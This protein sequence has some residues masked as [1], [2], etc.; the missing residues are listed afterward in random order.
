M[1][2]E[3]LQYLLEVNRLGTIS[4]AA[5]KLYMRQSTLSAIIGTLEDE[6]GV[7]IF[8]RSRKGVTP[9]PEGELVLAFAEDFMQKNDDLRHKLSSNSTMRRLISL[10][11]YP[12]AGGVLGPPLSK[13]ISE[14]FPDVSFILHDVSINKL[15]ST[16]YD[17]VSRI[18]IGAD[19]EDQLSEYQN[20]GQDYVFEKLFDDY[21]YMVVSKDSPYADRQL[22]NINDITEEHLV[23][24]HFY[25]S[26]NDAIWGPV[27]KRFSHFS[28]FGSNG[29]LKKAVLENNMIAL[30]PGL[31][32]YNDIYAYSGLLR[33][34][35][36]EGFSTKLT[37]FVI[38]T[39]ELDMVETFLLEEIR[40]LYKTLSK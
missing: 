5:S 13:R 19:G 21:F 15:L 32:L 27:I 26:V 39:T 4:A 24:A 8:A 20:L 11:A 22:I 2:T 6:V 14:K 40:N 25:P 37:N 9:T 1:R 28:V 33:C 10:I 16:L 29:V 18:A 31:A 23:F 7:K 17:G 34:I 35:R 12:S 3:Y 36:L 30:M 38:H